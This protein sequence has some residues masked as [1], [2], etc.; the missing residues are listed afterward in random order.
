MQQVIEVI[1]RNWLEKEF[2]NSDALPGVVLKGLAEEIYN[3]RWE[4]HSGVQ[5]EYDME[6][7]EYVGESEN[8]TEDEKNLALHRYQNLE[9]DRL[10]S[11]SYII[12]EIVAER[13]SLSPSSADTPYAQPKGGADA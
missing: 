6:D 2:G 13:N 4:I 1:I 3:H 7:I 8:L 9:D 5:R 11:L 10:E 12:D